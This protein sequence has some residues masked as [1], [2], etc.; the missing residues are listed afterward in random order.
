MGATGHKGILVTLSTTRTG[1]LYDDT[2]V[3]VKPGTSFA[4]H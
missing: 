1:F 2:G 4:F 3:I